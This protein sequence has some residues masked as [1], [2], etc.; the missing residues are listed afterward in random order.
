V[1]DDPLLKL[2]A[3]RAVDTV[4]REVSGSRAAVVSTEDGF[5]LAAA[6]ESTA[7]VARLS[8]MAS[9]LSALGAIAGEESQLG[10]CDNIM[11][12]AN[13]GYILMLQARRPD[14]TVILSI[15][16]GRNAV[17]GQALYFARRAVQQLQVV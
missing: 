11:I 14:I 17:M 4:M 5:E 1:T 2:A 10:A 12:E 13:E 8:A 7:Q 3:Q 6:V 16:T 9:A 15:V